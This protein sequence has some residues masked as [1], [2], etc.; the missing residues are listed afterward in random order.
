MTN[1]TSA[2]QAVDE[3]V[4]TAA[5]ATASASLPEPIARPLRAWETQEARAMREA[6]A[7]GYVMFLVRQRGDEFPN[8][9]DMQSYG[10]F[11]AQGEE[12]LRAALAGVVGKPGSARVPQGGWSQGLD[13]ARKLLD[14]KEKDQGND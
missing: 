1:L 4:A 6:A 13:D 3:A 12:M 11:V 9:F 5:L 7:M 8:A 2:M 14:A 10:F